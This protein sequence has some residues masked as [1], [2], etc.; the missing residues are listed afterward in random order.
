MKAFAFIHSP[1]LRNCT[2]SF[3]SNKR[4]YILSVSNINMY[5]VWVRL[6]NNVINMK[7][8]HLIIV[9]LLLAVL[10]IGAVSASDDIADDLTVSDETGGGR[11]LPL[12]M[13]K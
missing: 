8:K 9:S 6:I 3:G 12:M 11:L 13:L 2:N 1:F 7:A 4:L 5:S 10:T